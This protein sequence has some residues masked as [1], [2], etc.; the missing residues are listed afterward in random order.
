[1]IHVFQIKDQM[2]IFPKVSMTYG[3]GKIGMNNTD[4][5]NHYASGL[6]IHVATIETEIP[7]VAFQAGN[8]GEGAR[9]HRMDLTSMYSISVGDLFMLNGDLLV[10]AEDG[11]VNLGYPLKE[12]A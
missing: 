2:S 4:V 9:I 7:E 1:M 3:M 6:Y 8:T 11:F 12:V 5:L 10:V